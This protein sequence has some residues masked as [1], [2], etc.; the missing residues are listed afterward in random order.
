MLFQEDQHIKPHLKVLSII[1]LVL[2]LGVW[3]FEAGY[4]PIFKAVE[5]TKSAEWWKGE[6]QKQADQNFENRLN[7]INRAKPYYNWTKFWLFGQSNDQVTKGKN[8][9]MFFRSHLHPPLEDQKRHQ[10]Y[11][12]LFHQISRLIE[13]K[14]GNAYWVPIPEKPMIYS[15][16]LKH[17]KKEV[18]KRTENLQAFIENG[19]KRGLNMVNV[20]QLFLEKKDQDP[21]LFL[22]DDTHW[23][24]EGIQVTLTHLQQILADKLVPA[25]E[26]LPVQPE[27]FKRASDMANMLNFPHTIMQKRHIRT[28][29]IPRIR[30]NQPGQF[31]WF[32]TSFS[33]SFGVAHHFGH[34]TKTLPEDFSFDGL[35]ISDV[36]IS[37]LTRLDQSETFKPGTP[38]VIE[39]PYRLLDRTDGV[40]QL[41]QQLLWRK[42]YNL[43]QPKRRLNP[44]LLETKNLT[45]GA[46]WVSLNNDP[47]IL[48]PLKE[49][50]QVEQ[51]KFVRVTLK[52][53]TPPNTIVT[54]KAYYDIGP[55][56]SESSARQF[57]LSKNQH[58]QSYLVP[59]PFKNKIP[60]TLRLDVV[61]RQQKFQ[62][63]AIDIF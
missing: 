54:L 48:I 8:G 10:D 19:Q 62:L 3:L 46:T 29:S 53:R 32:G 52:T 45:P 35:L 40:S 7:L 25:S 20:L 49:F 41:S 47:M 23:S 24:S 39:F 50:E 12:T 18:A 22:P 11:L 17:A 1:W 21:P 16:H 56:F 31:L 5:A 55:G 9:W 28:V 37:V 27:S 61:N 14:G 26:S 13:A 4:R 43:A 36:L 6:V 15:Q 51:P 58:W 60:K 2:L 33:Y 59:I 38:F 34:L 42:H 30:H 44:T 63:K 57:Q